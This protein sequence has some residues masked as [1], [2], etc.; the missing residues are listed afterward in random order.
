[1]GMVDRKKFDAGATI[2]ASACHY[3]HESHEIS[4]GKFELP[5]QGPY[6]RDG[7]IGSSALTGR[8]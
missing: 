1:M 2:S 8:I 4:N 5:P 3:A 7:R 6:T